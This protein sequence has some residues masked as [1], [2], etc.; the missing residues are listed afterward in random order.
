VSV[1]RRDFLR[2]RTSARGRTLELSCRTLYKRCLD[3]AGAPSAPETDYEMGGEPPL[4]LAQRTPAEIFAE[5][6][7]DLDGA[8]V[9]QLVEPEWLDS[10]EGRDDLRAVLDTFRAR[11]GR[12]EHTR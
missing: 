2:L 12:I 5:I 3:A 9:L 1:S 6:A 8:Q 11:G 4:V 7:R 10:I